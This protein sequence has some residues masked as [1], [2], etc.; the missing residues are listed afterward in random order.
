MGIST[1]AAKEKVHPGRW[2]VTS[3]GGGDGHHAGLQAGRSPN[4][5]CSKKEENKNSS[6]EVCG[7]LWSSWIPLQKGLSLVR[8]LSRVRLSATPWTA[9]CQTLLSLTNS[10]SACSNSC[11]SS[12]IHVIQPCHPL[13]SPS[14][15][16][17]SIRVF[18]IESL[19]CI[20][21]PKY[22]SFSFSIHPSNEYLGLISFRIDWLDLLAVQEFR[23]GCCCC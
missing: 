13:L 22:W 4:K 7:S 20:M 9:V 11:P 3:G 1:A 10:C 16:F 19:L 23:K 5:R 12:R 6:R 2:H 21:W 18:S 15:I 14:S 8:W 17:R